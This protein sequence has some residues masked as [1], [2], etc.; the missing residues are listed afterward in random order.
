L[1]ETGALNPVP[2]RRPDTEAHM[3]TPVAF[4]VLANAILGASSIY[5]ALFQ[6]VSPVALV[7]Y[8]VIF[9]LLLLFLVLAWLGKFSAFIRRIQARD[10]RLHAAAAV[11]VAVNWGGLSSG[12][13]L[14]AR[15]WKAGSAI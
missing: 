9:S 11:L 5:W 12:R 10:I 15:C 7:G 8:R 1:A 13:P 14:A 6:G 4:A 2:I 3:P